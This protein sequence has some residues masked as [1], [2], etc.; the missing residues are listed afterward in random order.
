MNTR[1]II[2]ICDQR[3]RRWKTRLAY[4]HATPV[5]LVSV[6]HDDKLGQIV[7]CTTEEM[8]NFEISLLLK[9]ALRLLR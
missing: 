8:S 9:E 5:L 7:I 3:L 6:G 1:Q 4:E 2:D